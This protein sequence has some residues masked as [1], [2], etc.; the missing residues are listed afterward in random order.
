MGPCG[1]LAPNLSSGFLQVTEIWGNGDNHRNH[2]ATSL[3]CWVEYGDFKWFQLPDD[4]RLYLLGKTKQS[5][6]KKWLSTDLLNRSVDSTALPE[7]LSKR[8]W[9]LKEICQEIHNFIQFQWYWEFHSFLISCSSP[10]PMVS[11]SFHHCLG[12]TEKG[13]MFD[14]CGCVHLT[15]PA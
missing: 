4:P 9:W 11:D 10:V 1:V 3:P 6:L 8:A 2:G 5:N 12:G 14:S 15:I 7:H 13:S